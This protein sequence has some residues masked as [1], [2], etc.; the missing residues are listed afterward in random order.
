MKVRF[1][2]LEQYKSTLKTLLEIIIVNNF[3]FDISSNSYPH[4]LALK[5]SYVLF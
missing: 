2:L 4:L 1:N 5:Y 3:T